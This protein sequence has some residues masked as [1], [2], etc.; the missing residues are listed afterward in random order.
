MNRLQMHKIKIN[1]LVALILLS[2]MLGLAVVSNVV[3]DFSDLH[4]RVIQGF[5]Q[6][7]G[8]PPPDSMRQTGPAVA[9]WYREALFLGK[10]GLISRC[11]PDQLLARIRY[12]LT[13]V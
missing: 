2:Q 13:G 11:L 8:Q 7:A 6:L 10:S 5:D 9:Y 12:E 1:N 3:R 4:R